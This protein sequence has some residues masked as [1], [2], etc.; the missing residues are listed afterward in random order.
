MTAAAEIFNWQRPT[1]G[2]R[3]DQVHVRREDGE[4]V[5]IVTGNAG[6]AIAGRLGGLRMTRAA[7]VEMGRFL[8]EGEA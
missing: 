5:L 8:L 4:V 6:G 2:T 3:G 7:A 1:N